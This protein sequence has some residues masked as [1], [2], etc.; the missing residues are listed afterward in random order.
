MNVFGL[1]GILGVVAFAAAAL[2]LHL[3]N[4]ELDW[5][6]HYVSQFVNG[7]RGWLFPL[8]TLAH[9]AGN[10]ML[11]TGLYRSLRRG[12]LRGWAA[13]L[14]VV[15]AGGFAVSGLFDVEPPGAAPSLEGVIHRTAASASFAAEL[16]SLAL[17]STAFAQHRG[18]RGFGGASLALAALA[19]AAS[20][21]LATSILLGWRPGLAERAALAAFMSWELFAGALLMR[22]TS[23]ATARGAVRG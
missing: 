11:G 6:R 15:A 7:P 1:A 21:M 3:A 16:A 20:A 5:T 18:W 13:A 8:G 14:F 17:F 22:E 23:R 19:A 2:G 10:A 4:T 12:R 9:A